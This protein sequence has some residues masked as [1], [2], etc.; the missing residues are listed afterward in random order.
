MTL[1]LQRLASFYN[2]TTSII[3]EALNTPKG[4][5][6][7]K[8]L[9]G[10]GSVAC[11]AL[12]STLGYTTLKACA[13]VGFQCLSNPWERHTI[14]TILRLPAISDYLPEPAIAS[15]GQQ[16]ALTVG[17]TSL[18]MGTAWLTYKLGK[19]YLSKIPNKALPAPPI[20]AESKTINYDEPPAAPSRIQ[21]DT[22]SACLIS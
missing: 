8:N 22:L 21:R 2:Q 11:A 18:T 16:I 13:H 10:L 5:K 15:C 19:K 1:A 9:N 14:L 7:C 12:A 17:L 20:K 3:R 4:R 6:V